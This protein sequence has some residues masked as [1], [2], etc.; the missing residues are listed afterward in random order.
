MNWTTRVGFWGVITI[1]LHYSTWKME[2]ECSI[3]IILLGSPFW[4]CNC[5]AKDILYKWS[6]LSHCFRHSLGVTSILSKARIGLRGLKSS[7][8]RPPTIKRHI[9]MPVSSGIQR[10]FGLFILQIIV[11]TCSKVEV[12]FWLPSF[13]L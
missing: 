9:Y 6:L 11:Y 3:L 10:L 2:L 5:N 8:V 4:N 7:F 13:D 12:L 1:R